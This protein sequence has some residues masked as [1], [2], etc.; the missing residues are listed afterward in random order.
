MIMSY[1]GGGYVQPVGHTQ[2]VACHVLGSGGGA[3]FYA[4]FTIT[5]NWFVCSVLYTDA[6]CRIAA[7]TVDYY[8]IIHVGVSEQSYT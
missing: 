5:C 2:V 7:E 3:D 8:Q 1:I 6:G 4:L